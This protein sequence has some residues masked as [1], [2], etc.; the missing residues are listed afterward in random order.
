MA[1]IGIAPNAVP[2][3][4]DEMPAPPSVAAIVPAYNAAGFIRECIEGL[5]AAGFSP[6]DIVVVDDASTDD[7]ARIAR[8]AGVAPLKLARNSGAAQARNAG[9]RSV[10]ADLLFFVDSDVVVHPC[11][12]L[13]IERF[14][15]QKPHYAAIFGAYDRNPAADT[16]VSRFRNLLHRHVHLEG[17]GDQVTFW[18]GCG[19]LRRESFEKIGGFDPAQAMMEDVKLGLM[20]SAYGEKIWLDSALQGKHLKQWTLVSMVRTDLLHRAIPWARLLRSEMGG[21]S[22]KSLNLKL[23]GKLSGIAI[24]GSLA[25]LP[26]MVAAPWPAIGGLAASIALLAGANARFLRMLRYERGTGEALAAIPLLW[27][28]YLSACLGYAWVLLT[29]PR[30]R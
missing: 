13:R 14:F 30:R 8:D 28:H 25:S 3:V 19:A 21:A 20:L 18:T 26:L 29:S 10:A 1:E 5:I 15:A 4:R 11:S 9:A 6:S 16:L 7:T 24:A 23:G 27:L 12:R 22:G 2:V 17:H